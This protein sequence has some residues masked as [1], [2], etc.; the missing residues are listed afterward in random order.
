MAQW[1]RA[2]G[3]SMAETSGNSSRGGP[4][5]GLRRQEF[6][7]AVRFV[8]YRSVGIIFLELF[9]ERGGLFG[10]GLAKHAGKFEQHQR[11]RHQNRARRTERTQG[12][13]GLVHLAGSFRDQRRLVL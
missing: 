9:V 10:I 1:T 5:S 8:S 3:V 2:F 7:P 4:L 6:Q 12:L 11:L 13:S